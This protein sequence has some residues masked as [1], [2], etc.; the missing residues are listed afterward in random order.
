MLSGENH[1]GYYLLAIV[2]FEI[3]YLAKCP[4]LST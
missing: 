4:I 3:D 1:E 2:V